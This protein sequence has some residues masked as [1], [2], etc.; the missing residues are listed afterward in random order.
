[1][2]TYTCN[3]IHALPHRNPHSRSWLHLHVKEVAHRNQGDNQVSHQM[4]CLITSTLLHHHREPQLAPTRVLLV[5]DLRKCQMCEQM[6]VQPLTSHCNAVVCT[7][8][9]SDYI[10]TS[11]S[12]Q[13]PCCEDS[14]M[15]LLPSSV[16]PLQQ[17]S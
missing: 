9:I 10:A 17:C 1:M 14:A 11:A 6:L 7:K 8:C 15:N 3:Y 16:Q 12:T 2:Y 13:C 4:P 5:T